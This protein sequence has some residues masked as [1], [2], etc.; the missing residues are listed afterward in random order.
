MYVSGIGEIDA[1]TLIAEIGN[2]EYFYLVD[3]LASQLG[4]IPNVYQSTD[5]FCIGR[6][7]KR[8]LM[9]AKRILT[10]IAQAAAEKTAN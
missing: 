6:S 3:K 7:T 2:F 9:L 10:Q 4:I 8:V 5:K 1:A